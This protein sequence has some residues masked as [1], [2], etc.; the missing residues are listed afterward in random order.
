MG[1][2]MVRTLNFLL[3]KR[4]SFYLALILST[5]HLHAQ[6]YELVKSINVDRPKAVSSD[7]Q[8]SLYLALQ[9]GGIDKYDKHGELLHHYSPE[10]PSQVA[11]I[12]AW[13]PLRLF[14]FY[15]D[16]Q[17]YLFLDRFLT[18]ANRF[19]LDEISSFVGWSTVSADNNLWI[20][21]YSDFSLK[22]YDITLETV[23]I[24]QPLD[25]I[26]NPDN[27]D[28]T[29]IKEY[30]NLLFISDANSGI[31]VFD[32][33]GNYLKKISAEQVNHFGF[34]ENNIYFIQQGDMCLI[35]IYSFKKG[36]E[37]L[38]GKALF[39]IL[40]SNGIVLISEGSMDFYN[41]T[42]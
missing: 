6:D 21:D 16:F 12:E 30:Q 2:M 17:E 18:T 27:Y 11:L 23:I 3:S 9:D 4:T 42:H 40:N 26:L 1:N 8:G 19:S 41:K 33:L 39:L 36:V 35:D 7:K 15:A 14:V 24:Q 34:F 37:K 29:F 10:K 20:I 38:P 28:I 22:K 32:N 5:Q 31:L 13:N 25:L